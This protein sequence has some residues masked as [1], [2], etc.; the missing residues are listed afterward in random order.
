MDVR[1]Y[2]HTHTITYI[3]IHTYAH[4]YPIHDAYIY[5]DIYTKQHTHEHTLAC[6]HL[7]HEHTHI[8]HY[9]HI[10]T[11][12][13][14]NLLHISIHRYTTHPMHTHVQIRT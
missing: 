13:Y 5:I 11:Y 9:K 4:T 2:I 8:L 7:E 10:S 1:N 12:E 14:R 3:N 6:K